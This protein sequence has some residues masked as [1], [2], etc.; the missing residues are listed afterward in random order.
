MTNTFKNPYDI[1]GIPHASDFELVKNTWKELVKKYHPDVYAGDEK[2]AHERIAEINAAY[3]ILKDPEQKRKLDES[4]NST[5]DDNEDQDFSSTQYSHKPPSDYPF[6][7]FNNAGNAVLN[8]TK[9]CRFLVEKGFGNYTDS[10][11]RTQDTIL[12]RSVEGYVQTHNARSVKNFLID[13]V[14]N[15]S[16]M[17]PDVQENVLSTLIKLAEKTLGGYLKTVTIYTSLDHDEYEPLGILF[18]DK[19][20][21]N[22][23]FKNGVVNITPEGIEFLKK[24]ALESK[25]RIWESSIINREIKVEDVDKSPNYFR[26]FITYAL[27]RDIE[28]SRDGENNILD[29]TG[30]DEYQKRFDAFETG[31]GYLLH[32][33]NPPDEARIVIFIDADSSPKKVNG[34][35]GKSVAMESVK[36]FKQTVFLDGK[37]FHNS[38]DAKRFNFSL[39]K[40]DTRFCY[41]NDLNPDFDLTGIF[42]QITDDM[43]VEGKGTS[44]TVIPKEKKPKMGITTN[45]VV[46]GVGTSFERRTFPVEFGNFWSRCSVFGIK[47]STVIGKMLFDDFTEEDWNSFYNYGFHCIQRYLKE[48]LLF[49][50]DTDYK[51]K[52]LIKEIE[53]QFGDGVLVKWI[54]NWINKVRVSGAYHRDGIPIK[55]LWNSFAKEHPSH[56]DKEWTLPKFKKGLFDY[57]SFVPELDYNPHLAS[58]GD[59]MSARKWRVGPRGNQVEWVKITHIDDDQSY[60]DDETLEIFEQLA[61]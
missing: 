4:N 47:P 6:W 61:A 34:G 29:G 60:D 3:E 9:L 48:G 42:S 20:E 36:H 37:T 12:V 23:T 40:P 38:G 16:S 15:D 28:P 27:K 52:N 22:V 11:D 41:I 45:Y 10:M 18:D 56:A 17:H 35:N 7:T 32:S 30:S 51:L 44:K 59:T 46:G 55:Q 13:H 54:S 39:V 2:D 33:Y 53:G 25:G 26:D 50:D 14:E 19:E 21:C 31:F 49:Q 43:T 5:F 57:V 58:N 1:L 24:N 8:V